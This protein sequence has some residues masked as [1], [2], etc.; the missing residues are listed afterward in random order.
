MTMKHVFSWI[1]RLAVAVI[2][3]QTLFF[4]FSGASE[5]IA[6]FT[7][8]GI[9]PWG[10]YLSG[11]IE[12]ISV[13]LVLIRSTVFL[14][15]LLGMGVISGAIVSHLT[16]LGVESGND[17]GL[18]FILALVVWVCCAILLYRYKHQGLVLKAKITGK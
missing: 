14:G 2:L 15:A 11:T 1:L 18:L 4:K 17:G 5:S 6:I 9:E 3:A 13:V 7:K 12:L 10:R 16:V 8:L